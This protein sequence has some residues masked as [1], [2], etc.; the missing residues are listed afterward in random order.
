MQDEGAIGQYWNCSCQEKE[1][2]DSV[3]YGNENWL[4]GQSLWIKV[5]P[6]TFW[7]KGGKKV[8]RDSN[9]RTQMA[10][11]LQKN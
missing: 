10:H 8:D 3:L 4:D 1:T 2:L 6:E 9:E 5:S 11:V 7:E